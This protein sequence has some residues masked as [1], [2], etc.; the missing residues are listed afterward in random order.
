MGN[1]LQHLVTRTLQP[2]LVVR[3]RL[4]ALFEPAPT[5]LTPPLVV[6]ETFHP[7]SPPPTDPLFSTPEPPAS[8]SSLAQPPTTPPSTVQAIAPIPPPPT[9]PPPLAPPPVPLSAPL[10]AHQFPPEPIQ[11]DRPRSPSPEPFRPFSQPPPRFPAS[12]LSTPLPMTP[13]P[14]SFRAA[15]ATRPPDEPPT[16][17]PLPDRMGQSPILPDLPPRI[18]EPSE[19]TVVLPSSAL[20]LPPEVRPDST[21][22][23]PAPDFPPDQPWLTQIDQAI[24]RRFAA[25]PPPPPV[26][27][28]ASTSPQLVIGRLSVEVVPTAPSRPVLPRPTG[29]RWGMRDRS[30]PTPPRSSSRFGLG[31]L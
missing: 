17:V 19:P 10:Q 11:G 18:S 7:A 27:P 6:E 9:P 1:F 26:P 22:S 30:R 8:P 4:P 3:P 23:H 21:P 29:S 16:R 24:A 31:Q 28:P 15:E 2:Q 12:Q 25:I 13:P 5:P 20:R 14:S